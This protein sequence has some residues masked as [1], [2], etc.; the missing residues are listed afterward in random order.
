MDSTITLYSVIRTLPTKDCWD[1]GL[2]L[3]KEFDKF[4]LPK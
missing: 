2:K 3:G 4:H 1:S